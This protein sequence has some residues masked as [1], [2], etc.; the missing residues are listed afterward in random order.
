MKQGS[1]GSKY[2]DLS[3]V[4]PTRWKRE[5]EK[6]GLKASFSPNVFIF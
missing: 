3:L 6:N 5:N 2:A 1:G 4:L